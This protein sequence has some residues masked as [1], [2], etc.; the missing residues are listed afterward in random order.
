MDST[1][2]T[3]VFELA[4]RKRWA[5]EA[6]KCLKHTRAER[7]VLAHLAFRAGSGRV[8]GYS[9]K[10]I[11]ADIS[12]NEH[13]VV[14]KTVRRA[15]TKFQAQ[16]LITITRHGPEASE[17]TLKSGHSVPKEW[18]NC[19]HRVDI[20]DTDSTT[21]KRKRNLNIPPPPPGRRF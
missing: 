13:E 8:F 19:P 18:T 4:D 20:L 2:T 21:K 1:T 7:D 10:Q 14:E 16:G 5:R 12:A 3:P 15:I 9:L 17:Y 6:S 11:A